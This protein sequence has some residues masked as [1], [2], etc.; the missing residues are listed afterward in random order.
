MSFVSQNT[1]LNLCAVLLWQ[2]VCP[3]LRLCVRSVL[4]NIFWFLATRARLG[5]PHSAF[6]Y[7][8]NSSTVRGM[9]I[10]RLHGILRKY[11]TVSYSLGCSLFAGHNIMDLL[12][13]EHLEILAGI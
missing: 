6:Q 9:I 10:Y 3:S 5:L 1:S 13:R 12:E 11:F 2:I 4:L 8:L 7:T